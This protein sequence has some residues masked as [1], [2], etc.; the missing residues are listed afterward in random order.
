MSWVEFLIADD[1]ELFRRGLR[2]LIESRSE[3]HVCGEAE[4]G[5]VA[6]EK[7]RQLNPQV[8]LLDVTMPEMNGL[9]AARVIRK[10]NPDS[11]ILIVS[12]NDPNLLEKAAVD[13]GAHGFIQ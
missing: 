10:Q 3:W 13:V 2:T 12:Q 8:V 7:A 9:D 5:Q 11:E 4:N 6:V 1:H